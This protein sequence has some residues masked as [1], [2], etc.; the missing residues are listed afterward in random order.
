MLIAIKCG[1]IIYYT[2]L[3]LRFHYDFIPFASATLRGKKVK[4]YDT[5]DLNVMKRACHTVAT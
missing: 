5:G 3:S 2:F 1:L 4:K